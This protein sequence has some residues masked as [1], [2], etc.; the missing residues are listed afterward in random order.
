MT[1]ILYILSHTLRGHVW[2]PWRETM[3]TVSKI[4]L[5]V[6]YMQKGL[7][8]L[9]QIFLDLYFLLSYET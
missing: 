4:E 1:D 2:R 6:D 3:E 5:N 8:I 9:S 7:A